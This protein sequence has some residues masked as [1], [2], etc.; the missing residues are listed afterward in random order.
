MKPKPKQQPKPKGR[1]QKLTAR[2][3]EVTKKVPRKVAK[4]KK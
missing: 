2:D 4:D 1:G 3:Y